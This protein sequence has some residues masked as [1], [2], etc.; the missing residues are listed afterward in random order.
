MAAAYREA[1]SS[2]AFH[3]RPKSGSD[4]SGRTFG[5]TCS[6]QSSWFLQGKQ[7]SQV[8]LATPQGRP[9]KLSLELSS[10]FLVQWQGRVGAGLEFCGGTEA[11]ALETPPVQE[12]FP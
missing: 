12:H 5:G 11:D 9:K 4:R 1:A 3:A 10:G 7:I 6:C 8:S 2:V